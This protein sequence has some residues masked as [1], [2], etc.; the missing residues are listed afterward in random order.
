LLNLRQIQNKLEILEGFVHVLGL[1]GIA[2][3]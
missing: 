3:A 1:V 2:N